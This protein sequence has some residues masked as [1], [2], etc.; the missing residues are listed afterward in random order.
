MSV[1]IVCPHCKSIFDNWQP[2]AEHILDSHGGDKE[3][4]VW[5]TNAL[6]AGRSNPSPKNEPIKV[7]IKREK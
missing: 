6:S 1:R 5:A 7:R 3:R 2:Y 4:V